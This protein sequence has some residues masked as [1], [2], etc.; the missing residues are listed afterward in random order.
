MRT[1]RW[2][3]HLAAVELGLAF[4]L[5]AIPSGGQATDTTAG[6]DGTNRATLLS[7]TSPIAGY[8]S[9]QGAVY[10][11]TPLSYERVLFRYGGL[12]LSP[13]VVVYEGSVQGYGLFLSVPLYLTP[14]RE[15]RP[16]GGV[17]A[18]PLVAGLVDRLPK[19]RRMLRAG[20]EAG[21]AWTFAQR[22]RL[23]AGLW[24]LFS[25]AEVEPANGGLNLAF[26]LWL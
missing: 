12:R 4:A 5:L 1:K 11:A 24:Y 22:W 25:S 26:G 15:G 8:S 9:F 19:T 17:Y 14:R 7:L 16:Y 21:Y 6:D 3:G 18:G 13:N 20:A 2:C 23:S 10:D